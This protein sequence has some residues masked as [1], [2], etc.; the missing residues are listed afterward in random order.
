LRVLKAIISSI[1]VQKKYLMGIRIASFDATVYGLMQG[2]WDH[3]LDC[4]LVQTDPAFQPLRSYV[5]RRKKG[6]WHKLET[7]WK[8]GMVNGQC[9]TIGLWQIE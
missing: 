6:F 1:L 2:P 7:K 4:A 5:A 8:Y 3:P 9:Q